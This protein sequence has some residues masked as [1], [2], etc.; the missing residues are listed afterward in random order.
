MGKRVKR[1]WSRTWFGISLQRVGFRK[2][3]KAMEFLAGWVIVWR[4]LGR[5]PHNV[6]EYADWWGMGVATGYREQAVWREAWPEYAT[7]T[8]W[9]EAVHFDPLSCPGNAVPADG[10]TH[11]LE[12]KEQYG[13]VGVAVQGI[14]TTE[15]ARV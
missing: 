2:T 11:D 12:P 9:A 14:F 8:V 6:E 10:A 3:A 1:D 4:D 13:G 15:V 7:P 5:P